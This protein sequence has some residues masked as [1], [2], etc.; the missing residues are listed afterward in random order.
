MISFAGITLKNPIVVASS[1][2]SNSI[3]LLKRAEDNGAAGASLKL[4]FEKVPFPSQL[5]SYSLPGT[6]LFFGIDRRLNKDEGLELMRMGKEKTSLV[7]M[8]NITSHSADLEKWVSLAREFEEAGAD[9]IEAN[10]V[11]P[12]TGLPSQLL[13]ENV[14][15]ELRSGAQIGQV[16][17]LCQLITRALKDA[18]DIPV[19]PKPYSNHPRFPETVKAI[20]EGGADGMSVSTSIP[21]CLPAPDIYGGGN[22]TVP[23]LDKASLGIITGYPLAKHSIFGKI[24]QIKNNSELEIVASGGVSK[25]TDIVEMTMWGATAVGICTHLMWYGFEEIPTM[26]EG[27]SRYME[28]QEVDSLDSIRGVALKY[29][30]SSSEL[31]ILEG[32]AIVDPDLCNS[33]GLCLKPGHCVAVT[34]KEKARVDPEKCIG[35]SIC[36]NLC[37]KKAIRM[38]TF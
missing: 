3:D 22:P 10:L 7:L 5:R 30:T 17:E 23:L 19:V 33:C 14:L 6:G 25:W 21:V 18:L 32:A 9:M 15:E 26:L 13:G 2:L 34:M 38:E 37:P 12:H 4:T 16:P 20:E 1:P 27:L 36:V 8:A 31:Q 35:C 24:S 28:E 29:L 11:C